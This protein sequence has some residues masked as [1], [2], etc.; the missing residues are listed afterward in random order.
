MVKIATALVEKIFGFLGNDDYP[1]AALIDKHFAESA[2][3]LARKHNLKKGTVLWNNNH[4]ARIVD[5]VH[6]SL[7]H[8]KTVETH[9]TT[10][11]I[12]TARAMMDVKLPVSCIDGMDCRGCTP[13]VQ[14]RGHADSRRNGQQY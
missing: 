10:T 7:E 8:G 6:T 13:S 4:C 1:A 5:A 9:V 12:G 11:E 2:F 14:D 3:K